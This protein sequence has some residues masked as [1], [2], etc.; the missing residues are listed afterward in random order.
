[1]NYANIKYNDISNGDGVRV[2]LFVSGCTHKCKGCFNQCAWDF[3]YGEEFTDDV[4]LQIIEFAKHP[5]IAGLTLLGGEPFHPKNQKAVYD[6]VM[7]FKKECGKDIWCY[8]GYTIDEL[9][10]EESRAQTP[11]TR[12]LLDSINTL[13]DGK[14]VEHLADI[15]LKFRGSSNQRIID[16]QKYL[17]EHEEIGIGRGMKV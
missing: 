11:W 7:R 4:A 2:S 1:M 14:F 10:D 3:D 5:H 16:V 13:V 9:L 15:T 8:S 17:T 6:F 12:K